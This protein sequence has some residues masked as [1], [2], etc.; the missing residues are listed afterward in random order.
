MNKGP[1]R[2][3][4]TRFRI[5][6]VVIGGASI[7]LEQGGVHYPQCRSQPIHYRELAQICKCDART[8]DY[9]PGTRKLRQF[10][11]SVS[12]LG[13]S[14]QLTAEFLNTGRLPGTNPGLQLSEW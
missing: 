7:C 10:R 1:L 13:C 5:A 6:F 9:T 3:P 8:P 2:I 11:A 14:R 4:A 12:A